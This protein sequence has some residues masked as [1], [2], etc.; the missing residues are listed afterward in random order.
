MSL[1]KLIFE[2]SKSVLISRTDIN[3][4]ANIVGDFNPVHIKDEFAEQTRFKKVLAHGMLGVGH[5]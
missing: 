1:K 4:F 2:K 5:I 3:S